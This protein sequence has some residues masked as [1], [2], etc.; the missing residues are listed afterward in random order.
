MPLA[1]LVASRKAR[2][3]AGLA[4]AASRAQ[5]SGMAGNAGRGGRYP[6]PKFALRENAADARK[7]PQPGRQ[8]AFPSSLTVLPL[9]RLELP[10]E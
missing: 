9:L 5:K 2:A 7:Q 10:G 3:M 6:K 8:T 1:S 4:N